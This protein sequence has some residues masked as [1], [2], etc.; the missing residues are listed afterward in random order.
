MEIH[1]L[2]ILRDY[3]DKIHKRTMRVVR[4]RTKSMP[5]QDSGTEIGRSWTVLPFHFAH[6]ALGS[7]LHCSSAPSG[8]LLTLEWA[9]E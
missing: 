8:K 6:T 5:I 3:F 2:N 9:P 1:D 7:V 4:D